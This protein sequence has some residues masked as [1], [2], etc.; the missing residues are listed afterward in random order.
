MERYLGGVQP[1]V[2]KFCL[3]VEYVSSLSVAISSGPPNTGS[4][5]GLEWTIF[6]PSDTHDFPDCTANISK[7]VNRERYMSI[8]T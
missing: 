4:R 3:T 2:L 6:G 1:I 5:N 8:R 7:T